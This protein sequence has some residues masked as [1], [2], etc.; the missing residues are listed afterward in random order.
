VVRHSVDAE[1]EIMNNIVGAQLIPPCTVKVVA[2]LL[3]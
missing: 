2:S 3:F 1:M